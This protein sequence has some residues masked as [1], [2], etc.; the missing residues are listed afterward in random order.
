VYD[1]RPFEPGDEEA[2]LA[3]FNHV[4]GAGSADFEPRTLADWRYAY[5]DNPSGMRVWVAMKDGVCAAHYASQPY[6]TLV[7]GEERIFGQIIDSMVHPEH[8]RGL[9]RPGLFAEVAQRMLAATCGPDQDLVTFGLPIEAAWRMGKT[10]LRYE[11]VRRQVVLALELGPGFTELPAAVE[12]VAHAPDDARALFDRCAGDWSA[13]GWGA[14]VI[15]DR[16]YL[17][18]RFVA[19]P[20]HEYDLLVTRGAGGATSGFGAYRTG[21]WPIP[22]AGLVCDWLVPHDEPAAGEALCDGLV[23]RARA[24]G[25][26]VLL[27]ILP[28]WD[29]WFARFQ[30]WGF[31]VRSLHYLMS[32][33]DNDP[34]HHMAWLRD[35]WWYTFAEVDLV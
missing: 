22:G 1:I 8:R 12:P 33:R 7:E 28:P 27:A 9:K 32:G 31:R 23:A 21:E 29:P 3:T 15:R 2:I 34:R 14:A 16:A 5:T 11:L 13:R 6:R 20:R 18:W 17:D 30:S 10:F 25:A 26:P 24:A 4:F 19:N 35:R